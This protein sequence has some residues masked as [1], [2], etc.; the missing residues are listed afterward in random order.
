MHFSHNICSIFPINPF[1]LLCCYLNFQLFRYLKD[2][3]NGSLQL[4]KEISLSPSIF[5]Y[6]HIVPMDSV[7]RN[8]I[9][10][11]FYVEQFAVLNDDQVFC[12][13][14]C[15]C[16]CKLIVSVTLFSCLCKI[17]D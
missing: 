13:F 7:K 15:I 9:K 3:T 6:I 2:K 11:E 5:D 10:R 12:L 4:L 17:I 1:Y 14:F 16:Y 8:R